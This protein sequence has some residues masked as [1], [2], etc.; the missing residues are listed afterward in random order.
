[1]GIVDEDVV[2]VRRSTDMVAL[3]SEYTQLRKVGQRW[4]GLCPF[5]AEKSP[6]FS[7][8][9]GDGLYHC[10][11]CKASGDA[12]TFLRQIEHMDFVD[13]VESLASRAN[14]ALRYTE[15]GGGEERKRKARLYEVMERAVQWYHDRLRTGRGC[16]RSQGVSAR[17]WLRCRRGRP[18]R[19]RLGAGEL[20]P[21]H[22]GASPVAGRP[23]SHRARDVEPAQPPP[24]LLPSTSA[25]PDIRRAGATDRLRR[26]KAPRYRGSEVPELP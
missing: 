14:I 5:H 12:I 4:V 26:P 19:H 2:T 1:M 17:S 11:G 24:G 25:I 21:A 20:G 23:G 3:I 8:N 18:L 22:A 13:A 9:A 16:G 7:V 15:R 10:F 6:S